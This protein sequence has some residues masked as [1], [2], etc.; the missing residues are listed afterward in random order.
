MFVQKENEY[1]LITCKKELMDTQ[2]FVLRP[3]EQI[4]SLHT[5]IVKVD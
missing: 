5:P 2:S 1:S 4:K 3:T